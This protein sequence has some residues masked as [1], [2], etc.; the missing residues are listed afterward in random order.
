V[1][2]LFDISIALQR[3]SIALKNMLFFSVRGV[4]S[5]HPPEFTPLENGVELTVLLATAR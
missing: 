5:S 4:T 1:A 2:R 3:H